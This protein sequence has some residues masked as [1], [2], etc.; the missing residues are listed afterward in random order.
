V[1]EAVAWHLARASGIVAWA[2]LATSVV[3]GLVQST[4]VARGR[5]GPAWLR[6]FHANAGGLALVL[7]L[8]HAVGLL[9]DRTVEFGLLDVLVPL[10]STWR[11]VAVAWGVLALHLLLAVGATAWLRDRLPRGLWLE[12][13][14]AAAGAYAL[15]TAHLLTAGT[16]ADTR[17]LGGAA[18][19]STALVGGLLLGRVWIASPWGA[20]ARAR[21]AR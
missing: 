10:A 9:L 20:R 14:R 8:V 13:H 1:G 6:S 11:P 21:R 18:A 17:W 3:V 19:L 5:P 7:V 2:L 15:A 4:R 16:D 12:V